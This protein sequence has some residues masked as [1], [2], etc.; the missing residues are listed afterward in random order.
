M[1]SLA[2]AV[3]GSGSTSSSATRTSTMDSGPSRWTHTTTEMSVVGMI[4]LRRLLHH[5][6]VRRQLVEEFGGGF[7]EVQRVG[8]DHEPGRVGQVEVGLEVAHDARFEHLVA[9][10]A[11]VLVVELPD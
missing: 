5:D 1:T 2:R 6:Q 7:G 11:F 4:G 8:G 9:G 3:P 10:F